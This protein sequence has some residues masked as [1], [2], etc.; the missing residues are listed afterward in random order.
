M[1]L[2]LPGYLYVFLGGGL[3]AMLRHG[4]N[5]LCIPF[6]SGFPYGTLLINVTGSF[7]MGAIAG[8]LATRGQT[9]P[10]VKLFLLTGVLGGFTTFSAFSLE[11]VLLWER[12]RAWQAG[13]YVMAS[14]GLSLTAL[15][16]GLALTRG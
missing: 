6:A 11:A 3:G 1:T 15:I 12:G 5:R 2:S 13:G 9:S 8:W 4:I 16:A 7:L 14:V 10:T